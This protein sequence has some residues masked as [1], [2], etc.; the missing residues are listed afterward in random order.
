M[1]VTLRNPHSVL[2]ALQHRPHDVLEIVTTA[3]PSSAWSEVLEQ[4]RVHRIPIRTALPSSGSERPASGKDRGG[5]FERQSSSEAT[6]RDRVPL[7]VEQLFELAPPGPLAQ[8]SDPS[9]GVE[10]NRHGIWLALDCLQDPHNV[11]AVFRAAAFFGVRGIIATRD[12]SAPLSGTA[13]DVSAGGLES[14]PFAQPPNLARALELAKKSGV[15]V[16]GTS[17][18]AQQPLSS[19]KADRPWLIVIGNEEG[20][21]RRL[22]LE[23]CDEVCSIPSQGAVGSLNVSVATGI[24]LYALSR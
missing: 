24:L 3:N 6:V 16:L 18:H 4:A 7:T 22:T 11:G 10:S 23:L 12:R 19:I 8:K 17:E 14:I 5:K 13:Y 20:G 15:W 9:G 21:L 2:A 1:T